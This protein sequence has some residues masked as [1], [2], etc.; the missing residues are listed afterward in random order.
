[1]KGMAK[2]IIFKLMELICVEGTDKVL[3]LE[4]IG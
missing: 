3:T 1:M 4:T 2:V